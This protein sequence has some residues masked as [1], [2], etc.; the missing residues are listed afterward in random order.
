MAKRFSFLVALTLF[1]MASASAQR[2][3]A[4]LYGNVQDPSGAV[5]AGAQ[6]RV[7]STL[8]GEAYN[9]RSDARG[10][11]TFAFLPVGKYRMDVQAAGFAPFAETSLT[12]DAGQV[13]RY[14]LA[15]KVG[16]VNE[17]VSVSAE[18]PVVENATPGLT[19]RV[20]RLQMD[21]LPHGNRNFT[22]LLAL[23]NGFRPSRDGL[24]QLNGLA[25][26]GLTLTVD[27]VDGSGSAEISSPSMFQ[28]FNPI[29]VMSE[30]AMQEV[31]VSKGV[32]SAEY[33]HTFSGNINLITKSGTNQFHGTLFETGQ[34]NVF[35]ARNAVQ[36]PTDP[37]PPVHI[38]QF[39]GT[40]GGPL[41]R[42]KLFFFFA[43][44]GYRQSST[45]V[46]TGQVP[47][48]QLRNQML[49]AVPA[50]KAIL[51]YYPLPTS[52][53]NATVG[54]W[55]GLA[56][57]TSADNNV[58]LKG[59]YNITDSDR[60]TLRYNR[61]RPNQ[62]NPRFPPTFRRDYEGINE[63][64]TASFLHTR[65]SWTSETR[66]GINLV[67]VKRVET[68]W[69]TGATPAISLRSAG[70]DTQ[71]EGYFKKGY[72]YTVEEVLAKNIGKHA[73]KIGGLFGRRNPGN[74][75]EQVP[76]FTYSNTDDLLA[77][78][79]NQIQVTLPIPDYTARNWE[80]GLF[81]QDDVRLRPNLM[82]NLGIRH[83]YFSVLKEGQGRLYNPDGPLA[84]MQRPVKFRPP[85]SEIN[86]DKLNF[87]PRAGFTY[88]PG[89][90]SK[91]V[92][93]AGGG[94]FTAQPLLNSFTLVYTDPKAPSRFNLA[95]TDINALGLK[96]PLTNPGFL[97]LLTT[98]SVP[99]GYGVVDPGFRNPYS[100]Q[101]SFDVQR[102]IGST[103]GFQTGYTGNKGLKIAAAHNIN[104]P[105]RVTGNRPFPD[106]LQ[107]G[108]L[109][110][111]DFSYYHAWQTSL[112]KRLSRG[113]T[114]N[115]H[116]TWARA[117][118]INE[119]DFY[120]GNNARVQD[121]TNWRANK[122]PA[123]N[124][125]AHRA[126]GD[127]VYRLPF[128]A[129]SSHRVLQN[130]IGGWQVAG[131]FSVQSG[132]RLD[133]LQRSSYDFSRPDYIGGSI[134]ANNGDRFQWFNTAAFAQVPIIRA[135]GATA[136]PGNVGKY[137]AVGPSNWGTNLSLAKAFTMAE[138]Y[139]FQVKADAFSAFNHPLLGNPQTET[140][141][142]TFG[143]I[144]TVG[145]ARSMQLSA[146]MTF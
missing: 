96:Y 126:V 83:E 124:D 40:L 106:A 99:S 59:D 92:I 102:Q 139:R 41:R 116:Y 7:T 36:R 129:W 87:S 2:T 79:P 134:Y 11:F 56:S 71:G 82:L 94:F 16:G 52:P 141:S 115:V 144:L 21:E 34:N 35:N 143:R 95:A 37:K 107:S 15:L 51:D 10:D 67:D 146:R 17:S 103:W 110:N 6:V 48:Q 131:T 122:G 135:S 69:L 47:T 80:L 32:M 132:D 49:G 39:G 81:A 28:N 50:Y 44:E 45:A 72:S 85:D 117:M 46:S 114:F 20:S 119:G 111:S 63:S 9:T 118:S 113:L 66:F 98:R 25:A 5:V 65:P 62:L 60:L 38:N 4:T 123:T 78:R 93:R 70:I 108:W 91:T 112:R 130:V 86:A 104:V 109:N 3:T 24:M 138:K 54:L 42:N 22:S 26:G 13:L 101:W 121:E 73:L 58:V 88:S 14:P 27:G 77:N 31:V 105:D 75:D 128:G 57:T 12:L 53:V 8:T 140:T 90:S 127:F 30:D 23:E 97:A 29:K 76:T 33:A 136:R 125:I 64:G 68:L 142:A 18:A 84:A 100:A 1:A 61:L 74:Y 55:Q 43:Y 19:D 145:G 120:S 133:I 89:R 137:I